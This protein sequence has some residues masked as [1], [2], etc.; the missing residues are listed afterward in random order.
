MHE[1]PQRLAWTADRPDVTLQ[2]LPLDGPHIVC[3]ELSAIPRF[4]PDDGPAPRAVA[5]TGHPLN[6]LWPDGGKGPRRLRI[7]P[8]MIAG[9]ALG[10][11]R[12][13]EVIPKTTESHWSG[14]QREP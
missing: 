12:S 11:G 4:A 8:R 2:I 6:D 5:T 10:P 14:G 1:Q 3:G 13:G 7:A 9:A